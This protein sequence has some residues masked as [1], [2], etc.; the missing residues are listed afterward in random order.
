M[1]S[2]IEAK[3]RDI[4]YWMLDYIK[5]QESPPY[6]ERDVSSCGNILDEFIDSVSGSS[7]RSKYEWVLGKVKDVV[8]ELNDFNEKLNRFYNRNRPA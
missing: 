4:L 8:L 3:K 1:N 6:S 2:D 7:E 5:G